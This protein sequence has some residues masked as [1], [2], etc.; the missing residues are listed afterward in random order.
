MCYEAQHGWICCLEEV[1]A[2]HVSI[3]KVEE[4]A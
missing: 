3:E 4:R 1:V 2:M